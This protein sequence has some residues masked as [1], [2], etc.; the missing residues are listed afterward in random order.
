V[1]K[2]FQYQRAKSKEDMQAQARLIQTFYDINEN[3]Y[4][5]IT[6]STTNSTK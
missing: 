3:L 5:T 4:F 1:I 2:D 6:G